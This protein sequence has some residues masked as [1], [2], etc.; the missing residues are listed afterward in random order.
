MRIVSADPNLPIAA[1]NAIGEA[2]LKQ[3][4]AWNAATG[5]LRLP[6]SIPAMFEA[7][8]D[9]SP[10]KTALTFG[11][12]GTSY[13]EIEHRANRIAACLRQRGVVAGSV[14][15]LGVE[16]GINWLASMLGILKS[17]GACVLLDPSDPP[18]RLAAITQDASIELMVGDAALATAL[19]WPNGS[20]TWRTTT[21]C[22][23][24][25]PAATSAPESSL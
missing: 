23:S 4:H 5:D 24:S 8:A 21:R 15:G 16:P 7:Q 13:S 3:L 2:E 10:D 18:A 25:P 14:I 1:L 17:G 19:G 9:L 6:E 12:W 11:S 22:A 20:S